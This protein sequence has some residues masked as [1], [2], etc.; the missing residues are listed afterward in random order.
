M[1]YEKEDEETRLYRE[2][3]ENMTEGVFLIRSGDGM[4]VYANPAIERIFGYAPRELTGK[5]IS[6]VNVPTDKSPEEVAQEIIQS[7][8]INGVWRGEVQNIKKDGTV[9]WC[10]VNVSTFEHSQHGNI[11]AAIHQDITERKHTEQKIRKLERTVEQSPVTIVITNINGDIEYVNPKFTETTGYTLAE[12]VSKNPRILKSGYTTEQEYKR[13]WGTITSGGEWRGEFRNKK[14]DGRLYWEAATIT[15]IWNECGEITNF[16][17]VKEDITIRKQAEDALR[18]SEEKYRTVANFTYD[19]EAWRAPDGAYLYISPSCERISGYTAAEF[20]NNSNF[21]LQ[22]THPDDRQKIIEHH[23]AIAHHAQKENVHLDFRIITPDGETRWIDHSCVAVYGENGE[24]LGRREGNRDITERKRAEVALQQSEERYRKLFENMREGFMIQDIVEDEAGKPVDVRYLEI[25]PAIERFLGKPRAEIIGRTRNEVLGIPD[26][27]VVEANFRVA[28]TGQPFHMVR[29]SSGAKR[30]YES[31]S[32]SFGPGQVATLVMDIT[33]SKQAEDALRASTAKLET[34]VHVSPLAI[35]LLDINGNVQLWNAAAEQIFGWTSQEVIGHPNPVVPSSKQNEYVAWSSQILNGK[36]LSNLEAIRQRKDGSPI[37]VSISSAPI[38]DAAGNVEGRM[39]IVADITERK[40]AE[41]QLRQAEAKYRDI[42]ENAIEGIFQS[43]PDGHF[44]S[45]NAA[46]A[47]IFGY[48]SPEDMIASIA[49]NIPIRIYAD[50][51]HRRE[52]IRILGHEGVVKDLEAKNLR[53]DGSIIWTRTS[54]RTIRDADGAIL[55]YEGFLEDV[56][57][58]KRAKDALKSANEQLNLRIIEVEKLQTELREQALRDPLTGLYNRRYLDETLAREIT[59]A[60]RE[61]APLS[62]IMSDIDLFKI[63]NDTYG[64]PVGDKFLVEISNLMKNHARSSDI[65]CRYGG[66]EFLL[67]L[68][69]TITDS[70][71]KRAEEIR[72]K[73]A[74]LIVRYD[75]NDLMI[76]MSFGVATYPVHG[77]EAEEIVIKADKALYQSKRNGRNLVTIWDDGG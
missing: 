75:E 62:V 49:N 58:Q 69:A 10:Q 19:W 54:A 68:P 66:E 6:A 28:S 44:I 48:E 67:V 38:Y 35:T 16:L 15:P 14:K 64:H 41:E 70:A 7:L 53:K 30:W 27:E 18:E 74:D 17:A 47:R 76:T 43:A 45:V 23:K 8:K 4:I 72:Q 61:N 29:Y 31:F 9:F 33:E 5:H 59:R 57:E 3:V 32:Y 60:E 11:W 42:F 55:Y 22:I 12:V 56:T 2:I 24:W 1:T 37:E 36:P 39:A 51:D 73:C 21:I 34:L 25:N 71:K 65:V 20:M 52:F 13:L 77:K 40:Q 46:M 63:I 26:P 50:P